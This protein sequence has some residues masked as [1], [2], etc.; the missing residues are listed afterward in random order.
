MD[1][2]V[3]GEVASD[4]AVACLLVGMGVRNL[5]MN[6]F[7]ATRVRH[8]IRQLTIYQVQ[9]IAKDVLRAT[10]PKQVE[11]ILASALQETLV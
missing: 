4:P 10:T 2:S 6:P 1:L 11:D 3:C 9:A 7:L 5:S 8:A